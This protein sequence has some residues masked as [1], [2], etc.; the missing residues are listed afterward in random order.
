MRFGLC[1]NRR[2]VPQAVARALPQDSA[3]KSSKSL[4]PAAFGLLRIVHCPYL[5]IGKEKMKT[6]SKI[7]YY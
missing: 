2:L 4:L 1:T 6:H 5:T 7:P 3:R